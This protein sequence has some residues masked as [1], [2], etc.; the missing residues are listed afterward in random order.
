MAL[1]MQENQHV[2]RE[3]ALRYLRA[4]KKEKGVMLQESCATTGY[5]PPYA[6]SLLCTYARRVILGG[7]ILV[8]PSPLV[9]GEGCF[10]TRPSPW[11]RQRKH[12]VGPAV[13]EALVWG[14]STLPENSVG[15]DHK[16][17]YR[18]SCVP[19]RGAGPYSRT[20]CVPHSFTW[21]L[22]GGPSA[23]G[24]EGKGYGSEALFP[25]KAREP[26]GP[27][28][29][30]SPSGNSRLLLPAPWR[31]TWSVMTEGRWQG[32]TAPPLRSR[33]AVQGGRRLSRSPAVRRFLSLLPLPRS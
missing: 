22:Q 27:H 30:W 26:L 19:W 10:P 20:P 4:R 33:T 9:Q 6:A 15:R 28:P 1:T 12:V 14:W 24:G 32:T 16:Q 29:W 18:N 2:G 25:D 17:P 3:V 13:V 21:G 5:S 11:R 31:W 23:A 8:P 7:V